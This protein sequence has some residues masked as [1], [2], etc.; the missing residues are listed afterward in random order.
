MQPSEYKDDATRQSER[1]GRMRR[2]ETVH[3]AAAVYYMNQR[4]DNRVMARPG[5]L[6]KR[7]DDT[8]GQVVRT[9]H[10]N[11]EKQDLLKSLLFRECSEYQNNEKQIKRNPGKLVTDPVHQHIKE[12]RMMAI[13]P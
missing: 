5:S 8:R 3:S 11:Q 13:Q 4:T 12:G 9:S 10:H 7:L 1:S 6:E 2:H